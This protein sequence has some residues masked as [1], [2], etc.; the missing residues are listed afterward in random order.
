MGPLT[1]HH[2][3]TRQRSVVFQVNSLVARQLVSLGN[4]TGHR[5]P[6][7][8]L[9]WHRWPPMGGIIVEPA[10]SV[11]WWWCEWSILSSV[12]VF[13]RRRWTVR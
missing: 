6:T 1:C 5:S 3:K 7:N 2:L 12:W 4:G 10:A 13:D 9:I 11:A 8:M